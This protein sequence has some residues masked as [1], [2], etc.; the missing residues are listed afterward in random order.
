MP[1]KPGMIVEE[2]IRDDLHLHDLIQKKKMA[3]SPHAAAS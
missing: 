2:R 1:G 3:R